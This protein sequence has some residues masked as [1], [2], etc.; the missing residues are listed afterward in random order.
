[1][2][3]RFSFLLILAL[4]PACSDQ[5]SASVQPARAEVRFNEFI[6]HW[7]AKNTLPGSAGSFDNIAL[8]IG[9][10]GIVE[11]KHCSRAT[12]SGATQ[13]TGQALANLV[14]S[15]IGNGVLSLAKPV[16]PYYAEKK[17]RLDREPYLEA[18]KWYLELDGIKLRKLDDG[19]ISDYASW[20]CPA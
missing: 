9:Q 12:N 16:T 4:L 3:T 13:S 2:Q 19:E 6:G 15:D 18:G 11:Y 17:F 8:L 1:M 20:I 5:K 14:V 7:E 10:D